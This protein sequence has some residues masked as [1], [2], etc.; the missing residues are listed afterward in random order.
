MHTYTGF[1]TYIHIQ[2]LIYTYIYKF[3]LLYSPNT[4]CL[5]P[6]HR[7]VTVPAQWRG[8]PWNPP[9]TPAGSTCH[10]HS[11]MGIQEKRMPWNCS[12]IAD[13]AT[14]T[15]S[16]QQGAKVFLKQILSEVPEPVLHG[17]ADLVQCTW[18][19]SSLPSAHIND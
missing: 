4:L 8:L 12:C 13:Q 11:G 18:M 9:E 17:L 14:F 3:S 16:Y 5:I 19:V 10:Q 15:L 2:V 7:T 6:A 1:Y